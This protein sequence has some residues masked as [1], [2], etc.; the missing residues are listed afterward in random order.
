MEVI[1]I[2]IKIICIGKIKEKYLNLGIDEYLKRLTSYADVKIVEL[3][4]TKLNDDSS[5]ALIKQVIEAEGNKIVAK[6]NK[7]S[8]KI[9]LDPQGKNVTNEK[10]VAIIEEA[11]LKGK[12]ELTFIIGGSYGL[13]NDVLKQADFIWSFSNLVFTHQMIRLILLEQI[14]RGF[15]I[16]KN[17]PYHK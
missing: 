1:R 14:Y 16:M 15:K 3:S 7:D 12:S 10:Y 4:E 13:S 5:P 8:F 2:K 9:V 6:L 11:M 17:E